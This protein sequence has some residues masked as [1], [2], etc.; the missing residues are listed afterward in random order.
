[1]DIIIKYN[2]TIKDNY[3][4]ENINKMLVIVNG[5]SKDKLEDN[6]KISHIG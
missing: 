5:W 2:H 4:L 1:M 3:N 6:Y